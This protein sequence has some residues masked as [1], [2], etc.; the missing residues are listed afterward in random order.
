MLYS[1]KDMETNAVLDVAAKICLA[2]RTAPKGRG[3]DN[4]VTA[5]ITG[6]DL[7]AVAAEM[8]RMGEVHDAQ[9]FIRDSGNMEKTEAVV[10]LGTKL[11]RRNIPSCDF[12][13]NQG[14]AEAEKAGARCAFNQIDLGVALGS[15][16]SV[17]ANHRVDNRIM[18]TIGRAAVNLGLLGKEVTLAFGIPLS[19]RSKSPYFDR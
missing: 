19:V 9:F 18:Y 11:G 5:V 2:A 10:L 6:D 3:I 14:C 15:A 7:A 12:C 13:G 17:A 8:K 16:V 1:G 4:L